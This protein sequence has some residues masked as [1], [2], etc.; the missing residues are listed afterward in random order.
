MFNSGK[1]KDEDPKKA[2]ENASN[3]LNKGLGGGLAKAFMGKDF[4]NQA[5]SAIQMGNQAID[6]MQVAQQVAQTG[7]DATAEVVSITDTGATV[8]QN[9]VVVL[10]L[11]VKPAAGAEFQTA[12]QVMVSRIAVPRAGDKIKI[13][14]NPANPSQIAIV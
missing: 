8:N 7:A 9:P 13:K 5:N 1:K 4:V 12:A 11:K 6:S 14:Y 2:L 10:V 3:A